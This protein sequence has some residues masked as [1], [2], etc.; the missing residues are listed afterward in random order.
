MKK[1]YA[2]FISWFITLKSSN[3]KLQQHRYARMIL[4]L[5]QVKNAHIYTLEDDDDDDDAT[6]Y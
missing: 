5:Q 2:T 6:N 3:Y 1:L 4:I